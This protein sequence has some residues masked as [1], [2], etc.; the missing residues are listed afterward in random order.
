MWN[1][2]LSLLS[3]VKCQTIF[4]LQKVKRMLETFTVNTTYRD[5]FYFGWWKVSLC[6]PLLGIGVIISMWKQC[7]FVK[8]HDLHGTFSYFII[9]FVPDSD[10][11]PIPFMHYDE[12]CFFVVAFLTIYCIVLSKKNLGLPPLISLDTTITFYFK[13][14]S[15][16]VSSDSLT[17]IFYLSFFNPNSWM[18]SLH[19]FYSLLILTRFTK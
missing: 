15:R 3:S 13:I 12:I 19:S 11:S 14:L 1:Y 8:V 5:V 16:R 4:L 18:K 10:S 17:T 9:I 7:I 6:F 2:S